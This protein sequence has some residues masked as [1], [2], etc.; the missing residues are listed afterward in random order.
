MKLNDHGFDDYL[1]PDEE[2][3]RDFLLETEENFLPDVQPSRGAF[4]E[5]P[6][7]ASRWMEHAS[8]RFIIN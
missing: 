6:E 7:N 3:I 1:L 5:T 8:E 2:T 4:S